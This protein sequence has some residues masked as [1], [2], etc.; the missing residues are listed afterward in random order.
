MVSYVPR[1]SEVVKQISWKNCSLYKLCPSASVH[2]SGSG[3]IR[4]L[5]EVQLGEFPSSL[6]V[7]LLSAVVSD[8]HLS[9]QTVKV[10]R[11]PPESLIPPEPQEKYKLPLIRSVCAPFLGR[12]SV[13]Q[14]PAAALSLTLPVSVWVSLKGEVVCSQKDFRINLFIPGEEELI[15]LMLGSAANRIQLDEPPSDERI[16][17]WTG[18][19][20]QLH[21]LFLFCFYFIFY[22]FT[23]NIFKMAHIKR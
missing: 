16:Q 15:L 6:T 9:F 22:I 4:K 10:T 13:L 5:P 18:F 2:L 20:A 3:S 12:V 17:Q 19:R 11:L 7:V 14:C 23:L 8:S 21:L 1:C